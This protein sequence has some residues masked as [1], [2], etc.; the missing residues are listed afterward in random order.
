MGATRHTAQRTEK[1]IHSLITQECTLLN[2]A[3]LNCL[4]HSQV[5]CMSRSTVY[6]S[7]KSQVPFCPLLLICVGRC[8]SLFVHS[9]P[10]APVLR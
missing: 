9:V 7:R 8:V 2:S 4:V 6:Q 10:V 1:R 3:D 5:T